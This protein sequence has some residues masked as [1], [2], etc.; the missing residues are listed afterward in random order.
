MQNIILKS[1]EIFIREPLSIL[2][3]KLVN[4]VNIKS[5]YSGEKDINVDILDNSIQVNVVNSERV[6]SLLSTVIYKKKL[7]RIKKIGRE[8]GV[9]KRKIHH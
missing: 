2:K 4:V 1:F 3:G 6:Y 5:P 7:N 8:I 9:Q